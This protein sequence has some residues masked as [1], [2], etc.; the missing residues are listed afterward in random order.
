[1]L[2]VLFHRRALNSEYLKIAI[3]SN[4]MCQ[5]LANLFAFPLYLHFRSP[6]SLKKRKK[7]GRGSTFN[8][9]TRNLEFVIVLTS[10]REQGKRK[11]KE[12]IKAGNCGELKN[13]SRER[14]STELFIAYDKSRSF[15]LSA[16]I[17]RNT[18]LRGCPVCV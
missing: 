2:I 12:G 1:M 6:V 5:P 8:G 14:Y 3:Y 9:R 10:D 17:F 4:V 11:G 13:A 15:Y 18:F 7:M 16:F